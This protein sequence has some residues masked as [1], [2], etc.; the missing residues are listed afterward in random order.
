MDISL[1]QIRAY[2]TVA[3]SRSFTRAAAET[4]LSQPALSMQ[5]RSLEARLGIK[6]FDR[7]SRLVELTR[8]GRELAPVFQ[9]IVR[10]LDETVSDIRDFARVGRGSVRI[11]ALPSFA[12]G[13]LPEIIASFRKQIP[14]AEVIVKDAIS[15]HVAEMVLSE[16]VELGVIGG[17]SIHADLDVIHRS[18]DRLCA[19]L[20]AHHPL[21]LK[22]VVSVEDMLAFPLILMDPATSV[23]ASIDA[24]LSRG[25]HRARVA[26]EVTYM[27]TAVAMVR[28]GLGITI[29]PESAHEL[30]AEPDLVSRAI[31]DGRFV[32]S[33]AVVKKRRRTLSPGADRFMAVLVACLHDRQPKSGRGRGA[34]AS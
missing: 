29:L 4:N 21:A 33:V 32:R 9:R 16:V 34:K 30:R 11:G 27:M 31:G 20:P 13:R 28:A 22:K 15:S 23:R 8:L 25:K 1:R 26:C 18:E 3:R 12:A 6:L 17:Q 7:S 24:A 10:D 14:D 2:L 5:I 19:V